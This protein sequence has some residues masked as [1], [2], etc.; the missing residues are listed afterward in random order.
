MESG[1]RVLERAVLWLFPGEV[2]LLSTAPFPE[3]GGTSALV[4]V[5]TQAQFFYL[6][7]QNIYVSLCHLPNVTYGALCS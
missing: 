2:S 3:P 6:P 1:M 5:G 7:F 4:H